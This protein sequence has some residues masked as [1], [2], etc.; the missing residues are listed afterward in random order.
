MAGRAR[1]SAIMSG[2][3]PMRGRGTNVSQYEQMKANYEAAKARYEALLRQKDAAQSQYAETSKRQVN[4]EAG[5]LRAQS[6]ARSCRLEHVL[7][8]PCLPLMTDIWDVGLLKQASMWLP[9][10]H[11]RISSDRPTNGLRPIIARLRLQT[12]T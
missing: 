5:I 8:C 10:K 4:M 2:C 12:F 9:G 7:H 6:R 11:C 1:L 3:L